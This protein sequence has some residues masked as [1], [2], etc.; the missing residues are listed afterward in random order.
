VARYF[1]LALGVCG[2]LLLGA[3]GARAAETIDA[4]IVAGAGTDNA[5]FPLA[6]VLPPDV[7]VRDGFFELRPELRL[8]VEPSWRHH[9]DVSYQG[10]WRDFRAAANGT[11]AGHLATLGYELLATDSLSLQA[12]ASVM[13]ETFFA[14]AGAGYDSANGGVG[15]TWAVAEDLSTGFA[16][17]GQYLDSAAVQGGLVGGTVFFG[18]RMQRGFSLKLSGGWQGDSRL[19]SQSSARLDGTLQYRDVTLA[20]DAS[21]GRVPSGVYATFGG[22]LE[23]RVSAAWSAALRYRGSD[24]RYVQSG[25][26]EWAHSIGFGLRYT[27]N[28]REAEAQALLAFAVSSSSEPLASAAAGLAVETLVTVE[29]SPSARVVALVGSFNDWSLSGVALERVGEGRWQ[30]RVTLAPGRYTYGVQIDGKLVVPEGA[31]SYAVDGFGGRD[32]VLVVAAGE[33]ARVSLRCVEPS[34]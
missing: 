19:F 30:A 34:L 6:T 17:G 18:V 33:P 16:L 26:A 23:V 4:E 10:T 15:L 9:L 25:A 3:A 1:G 8:T 22:A 14:V 29:L 21:A 5:L 7:T 24:E 13:R 32:A 27:W 20:V 2:G 12:S 28:S 31:A 11:A